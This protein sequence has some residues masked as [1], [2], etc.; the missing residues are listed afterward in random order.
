MVLGKVVSTNNILLIPVISTS[1]LIHPDVNIFENSRVYVNIR[2][3]FQVVFFSHSN[4][5]KTSVKFLL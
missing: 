3:N 5:T 2:D 1:I 4:S